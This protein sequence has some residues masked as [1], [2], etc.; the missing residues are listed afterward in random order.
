MVVRTDTT[1]RGV[2]S[3][4]VALASG[5][6][7]CK[8]SIPST[9]HSQEAS[10]N[11]GDSGWIS[12]KPIIDTHV[13]VTDPK[14][15]G[16]PR[17][18]AAEDIPLDGAPNALARLLAKQMKQSGT[19]VTM[20]MPGWSQIDEKDPL[21]I[22]KT[23]EVAALLPDGLTLYAIG[24]ADPKRSSDKAHMKRVESELADGKVKALKCYL[25]YLPFGPEHESRRPYYDLANKY[26]IPVIFHTG[27]TFSRLA[28]LKF[29]HPLRVDEVAVDYPEAKFVVAHLGNPWIR[30]AAEVIYKNNQFGEGNVWADL[31][32]LFV[33]VQAE[34]YEEGGILERIRREVREAIAF[35][36]KPNRF[37]FGSDWPLNSIAEYRDFIKQAV[38][39]EHHEVVFHDNAADL[40]GL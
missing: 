14:H 13:H 2:L 25:G 5:L 9:L 6:L 32:A 1:R 21:A 34:G 24:A 10:A 18:F 26:K 28:K 11:G 15:P 22:K 38:P 16:V 39:P 19:T 7:G 40:Y 30:D 4:G 8:L 20:G 27:D 29:A 3:S 37:M 31:S 36:E 33:G 12:G 17:L 35:T 23:R